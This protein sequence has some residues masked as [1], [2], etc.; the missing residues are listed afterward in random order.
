MTTPRSGRRR[1]PAGMASA[2]AVQAERERLA[3]VLFH[4]SAEQAQ[5]IGHLS[6]SVCPLP[7]EDRGRAL[8]AG[9]AQMVGLRDPGAAKC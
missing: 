4:P 2:C 3:A 5:Q 1:S 9:V 6:I 8:L 7:M